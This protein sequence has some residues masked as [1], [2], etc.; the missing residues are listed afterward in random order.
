MWS[1]HAHIEHILNGRQGP[2]TVQGGFLQLSSG[3]AKTSLL[4]GACQRTD[5]FFIEINNPDQMIFRIRYI[6]GVSHQ[7]HSL[8]MI[9]RSTLV[10]AVFVAN[11]ARPNDVYEFSIQRSNHDPV[12]VTVGN[13]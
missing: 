5:L 6:Q 8:R 11:L 4:P 2:G 12:M 1:R 10:V 3:R 7:S 9:K 13:E